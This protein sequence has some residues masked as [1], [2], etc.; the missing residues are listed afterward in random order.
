MLYNIVLVY[1]VLQSGSVI[2][3]HISPPFWAFYFLLVVK[4]LLAN[5][6]DLRDVGFDPWDMKI[7]QRRKWQ[8]TPVFLP[9]KFRRQRSLVGYSRWGCKDTRLKWLS[10][11]AFP[12]PWASHL[13]RL[14]P[15]DHHRAP[16][17]APCTM[18]Q[19]PTSYLFYTR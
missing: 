13:P 7:P 9:G 2:C 11:H 16:S 1:A 19:L 15:L 10:M 14:I 6:G 18:Q 4:N 5:A 17:W 8:P 12:S 3:I